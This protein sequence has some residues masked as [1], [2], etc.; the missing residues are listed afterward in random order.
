MIATCVTIVFSF[1][2]KFTSGYKWYFITAPIIF[3]LFYLFGFPNLVS[4]FYTMLLTWRYPILKQ[5]QLSDRERVYIVL[6]A[7][8]A[9]FLFLLTRDYRLVIF[10]ILQFTI[11][12]F[13]HISSHAAII[14]K[15]RLKQFQLNVILYY[16]AF[17]SLGALMSGI[18]IFIGK[19]AWEGLIYVIS[20]DS[21][22]LIE[23]LS[24]LDFDFKFKEP[25][26]EPSFSDEQILVKT[27]NE[28]SI[29]SF[30]NETIANYIGISILIIASIL[31]LV[32]LGIKIRNSLKPLDSKDLTEIKSY[33]TVNEKLINNMT[34]Q[35]IFNSFFKKPSHPVRKM[36]YLFEREALKRKKGRK[37]FETLEEWLKRIGMSSNISIYQKVRYGQTDVTDEEVKVLQAQLNEMKGRLREE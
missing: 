5:K 28:T 13:G 11:L 1:Y 31:F 2:E 8:L 12:I 4:I 18:L 15:E 7:I 10:T 27:E 22:E 30:V 33:A 36:V 32:F 35:S 21:K 16:T 24:F 37:Y 9:A 29:F 19:K 26:Y 17:L 34:A 25:E 6:T 14:H 23:F 20:F 3:V